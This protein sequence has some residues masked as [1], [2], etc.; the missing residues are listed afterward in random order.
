MVQLPNDLNWLPVFALDRISDF[1]IITDA[2]LDDPEGPHIIYV[3]RAVIE[4]TGYEEHEL[5]GRSPRIFQGARPDKS[6]KARVRSSLRDGLPLRETVVNY[7]K[8]GRRYWTELN[9]APLRD[10]EGNIVYFL[11]IQRDVT[12]Q[13]KALE[14]LER[15][16]RFVV[17]G[18]KIGKIGTWGYDLD[19]S[20]VLWSDGTYE[21]FDWEK[22]ETP[23]TMER[24][25]EF[26]SP[27]NREIMADLLERCITLQEPY[28]WETS[29][30]TAKGSSVLLV[31]RGEPLKGQDG[32][33]K[34]IVGAIRDVTDEKR[35]VET[36]DQTLSRTRMLERHFASARAAAK[37]GIFDYS[38]SED[39]QYWSVELLDMTGLTDRAF[40][41]PAETF[42]SRIDAADRP[43]FDA[44]FARAVEHGEDY[45]ITVRFHRPDGRVVHMQIVAEVRDID[46]DRRI[47]GIARDVTK[48]VEASNL[49]LREKV[50][51]E[52]IADTVSDVLWDSEID[53]NVWWVSPN[54]PQKLGL[55]FDGSEFIPDRWTDYICES[56]R[57]R[58]KESLRAALKSGRSRWRGEFK[59]D[60]VDGSRVDVE[61]NAT[62]LRRPDG[63]AYRMLGNLRNIT[64][65]NRQ[66]EGTTRSRALEAVGKMT[67]GIAHDFNNLLMII[68]G[69]AE[70]LALSPL[71]EEDRNS[72][73]LIAKASYAA[74]DLTARLL[75]FSGQVRLKSTNVDLRDLLVGLE[76]LLRSGLTSAVELKLSVAEEIWDVEVD[77]GALEQAII[78]LAVN[79]RDAMPNG[80]TLKLAC[81]NHV[82]SEEM[83]AGATGLRLGRYVRITISDTG[84]GMTEDVLAKACEPFFT[85]KDVGKGTGLGLSTVF[86]FARQSGGGLQIESEVGKGTTISLYLPASKGDLGMADQVASKATPHPGSKGLRVLVVEDQPEIRAHVEKLLIRAGYSVASAQDAQTALDILK[87]DTN[88]D[89]LFTDVVMPGGINGVQLAAAALKIIPNIKILYTSGF[90]A[91]AFDEIGVD[92]GEDLAILSKPFKSAELLH[93]INQLANS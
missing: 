69:N 42:I 67:G 76:P 19:E 60:D 55:A 89:I 56:D 92:G 64:S 13:R 84:V 74:A 62:I 41:A 12:E 68:Q 46:G 32:R 65:E 36:L 9:I 28:Q 23:P 71:Q 82:V 44:L 31:V 90:P 40:P 85:T 6:T 88:Y 1:V 34:A 2:D 29:A 83:A 20:K 48:E 11:S 8:C 14:E 30:V 45:N 49:L 78:N 80:G 81:E 70:M 7:T 47:V 24:M 27:E 77:A 91:S 10:T 63:W 79:A 52:I 59:V 22:G 43:Q 73:Q 37:I 18:E 93:A 3:N 75:S 16:R 25:L 33:T 61:I 57:A 39:L 4:T 35:T 58:A 72:V 54:W 26:F 21:I 66:R 5:L 38:I 15:D 53:R 50:R 17:A 87:F 51:F 86:G